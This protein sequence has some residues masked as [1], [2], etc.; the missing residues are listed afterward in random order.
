MVGPKLETGAKT[1]SWA[2][3]RKHRCSQTKVPKGAKLTATIAL[4][5][6]DKVQILGLA[7][8]VLHWLSYAIIGST[9][10]E[11]RNMDTLNIDIGYT[12]RYT[13]A[14]TSKF[15]E[16]FCWSRGA[17]G[18]LL[19]HSM[20][21]GLSE[22]HDWTHAIGP[23]MF[24]VIH[25]TP[26]KK[27]SL[28]IDWKSSPNVG[29]QHNNHTILTLTHMIPLR[30]HIPVFLH[31][32]CKTQLQTSTQKVVKTRKQNVNMEMIWERNRGKKT[33]KHGN[34][35]QNG[36]GVPTLAWSSFNTCHLSL[37]TLFNQGMQKKLRTAPSYPLDSYS[38]MLLLVDACPDFQIRFHVPI[39]W[40]E[41]SIWLCA[42]YQL[43]MIN[44]YI[45]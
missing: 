21:H 34:T 10:T 2:W 14:W 41:T 24:K 42:R 45:I 44:R 39:I 17:C 9:F 22:C 12:N 37:R 5:R 6:N 1:E 38:Y 31:Q 36:Y 32:W 25:P 8:N 19:P 11:M 18:H 16:R 35:Q 40:L 28:W 26:W 3:K 4:E 30:Q 33:F 23:W 7:L 29:I 20:D 13:L 15:D 27:R 43:S